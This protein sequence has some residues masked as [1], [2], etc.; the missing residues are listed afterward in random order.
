MHAAAGPPGLDAVPPEE[1]GA[2]LWD[3]YGAIKRGEVAGLEG[4]KLDAT[5]YTTA[6]RLKLARPEQAAALKAA[7]LPGLSTACNLGAADVFPATSGKD[8]AARHLMARWGVQPSDC[9][10]MCGECALTA[11]CWRAGE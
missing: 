3:M 1:R 6:F 2:A 9:V 4:V 8:M 5:S 11:C 10:F 7:L